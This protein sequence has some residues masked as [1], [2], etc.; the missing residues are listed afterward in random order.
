MSRSGRRRRPPA[1]ERQSKPVAPPGL[2]GGVYRPLSSAEVERIVA[3]AVEVLERTGIEV[4]E[5]PCREVFR[6]AGARVDADNDRVYLDARMVEEGL[7]RAAKEVLLAGR[8]PRHDLRLGGPRVY[9]GTGGQAVK[10]LD[11]DG[12]VRETRLSDNYHIGRLCDP[13]EHIH[14]YMR[15]VVS[16]DLAND[17]IDVN[18][19]YACLAATEKHVMAN[20]Y[21]A[22]RVADLRAMAEVIAGGP[23][24]LA[25]RPV[26][27]FTAC[28]TVSPLRYAPETVEILDRLVAEGLPVVIASAPQA[29]AT[30]P[31]A[32]AGAVVQEVAEVLGGLVY[33]NAVAQGAPAIFGPWP[34]VS[35]LR[36]GAMSGGS[37]EQGLLSAA[38]AQMGQFYDLPTGVPAGMTDSKLPDAQSGYEKGYTEALLGLSGAN[39]IYEAAGMHASLLGFC[40]ESLVIDN[41]MIGSILRTIR[42]I[43]VTEDSLSVETMRQV[44]TQGPGHFLGHEQTLGLM[45]VEYVYPE[46][47]DRSSPKEWAEAGSSDVVERARGK[48]RAILE[49]HY[50]G[51]VDAAT[52]TRIRAAFDIKLPREAMGEAMGEAM[53]S[54]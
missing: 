21:Q 52:D 44:C 1:S 45:Q 18:Q 54:K 36:T 46:V 2:P 41:D 50:P 38:C 48:T 40:F 4:V 33:V 30:S 22:E 14:F 51:Q 3:A 9:M 26:I 19:F 31:A 23:E 20:A 49:R 7:A 28:W 12:G 27:S 35:D 15:P 42:G 47:G 29:G 17:D 10:I 16:R 32:L 6:K 24:A 37:G 5:S 8:A 13:L 39:L 11:L 25:A 53:E 34:F 43:E